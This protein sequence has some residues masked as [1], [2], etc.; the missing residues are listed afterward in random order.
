MASSELATQS[1]IYEAP[2]PLLQFGCL[3]LDQLLG[4]R[5]SEQILLYAHVIHF[6]SLLYA[7]VR[8]DFQ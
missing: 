4:Y 8:V 3:E 6:L 1:H 5:C 2:S 7:C